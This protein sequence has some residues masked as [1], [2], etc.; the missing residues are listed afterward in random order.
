MYSFSGRATVTQ[1]LQRRMVSEQPYIFL[2]K[3][4]WG[5]TVYGPV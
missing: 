5:I 3:K 4:S 2:N 1:V